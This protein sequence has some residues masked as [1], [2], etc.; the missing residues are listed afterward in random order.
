MLKLCYIINN[1]YTKVYYFL[2]F[3]KELFERDLWLH[4]II[5][6]WQLCFSGSYM[7]I[8]WCDQFWFGSYHQSNYKEK[9]GKI[10][11]TGILFRSIC[12]SI[13]LLWNIIAGMFVGVYKNSDHFHCM[14]LDNYWRISSFLLID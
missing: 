7:V 1:I 13:L 6:T 10:Y 2:S 5:W 3:W 11:W 8:K 14:W 4:R 9:I 12:L